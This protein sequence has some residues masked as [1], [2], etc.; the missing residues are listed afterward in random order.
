MSS[1]KSSWDIQKKEDGQTAVKT[2]SLID[3]FD[4]LCVFIHTKQRR[5]SLQM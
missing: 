4:V 2:E 3:N 5:R 1:F